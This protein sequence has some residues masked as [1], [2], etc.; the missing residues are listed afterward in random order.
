VSAAVEVARRSPRA[1]AVLELVAPSPARL[2]VEYGAPALAG[3][4]VFGE[5][6]P[7]DR[8]WRAGDD[9]ATTLTT[10]VPLLLGTKALDPG[11]YA[12]FVIPRPPDGAEPWLLVVNGV[13]RQWGAF[14]HDP[15]RDLARLPLEVEPIDRAV[16]RLHYSWEL[17]TERAGRLRITWERI[18]ASLPFEIAIETGPAE[19]DSVE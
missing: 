11:S 17:A 14:N 9:E 1:D 15:A 18:S 12:L 6:V 2:R 10:N 7:W 19:P 5:L 4:R 3:R 13:A 16:E 8:I